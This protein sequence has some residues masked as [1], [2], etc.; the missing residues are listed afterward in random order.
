MLRTSIEKNF[1]NLKTSLIQFFFVSP[2]KL[3]SE[4]ILDRTFEKRLCRK[5]EQVVW[6]VKQLHA[7]DN[8]TLK[9]SK[10]CLTRIVTSQYVEL[11]IMLIAAFGQGMISSTENLIWGDWDGSQKCYQLLKSNRES[12]EICSIV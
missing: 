4:S 9:I 1:S 8:I 11:Q 5:L 6:C 12:W 3:P 2:N 10:V 7:A